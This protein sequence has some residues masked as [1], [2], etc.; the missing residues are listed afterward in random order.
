MGFICVEYP[1][2]KTCVESSKRANADGMKIVCAADDPAPLKMM[3]MAGKI[4]KKLMKAPWAT[5]LITKSLAS[6]SLTSL[7]VDTAPPTISW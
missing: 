5:Q 1:V 3:N 6:F 7:K 4:P 2:T